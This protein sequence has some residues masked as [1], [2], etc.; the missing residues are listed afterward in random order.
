MKLA[1]LGRFRRRGVRARVTTASSFVLAVTLACGAVSLVALVDHSLQNNLDATALARADDVSATAVASAVS[2]VIPSGGDDGSIVQIIDSSGSVIASSESTAEGQPLLKTPPQRREGTIFTAAQFPAEGYSGQFRIVAEPLQLPSG[3]GW[4]YVATSLAQVRSAVNSLVLLLG[5][6]LP[7]L[8]VIVGATVWFAVGRALRPV[9]DIRKRAVQ[10]RADFTQRI[11]LPASDDEIGRLARTVNEM[12]DRL[13]AAAGLERRF[14]GDA[15]HELRS[16][17]AA[18]RSQVDVALEHPE[19]VEALTVLRTIQLQTEDMTQLL[20]DLL[21][22]ARV[23]E[24]SPGALLPLIDLDEIL[25]QEVR[26]LQRTTDL[27]ISV[28]HLDAVRMHGAS[29]D[30]ARMIANIGD[31]ASNYARRE[32]TL[33]LVS[34][35]TGVDIVVTDDGSGI[36]AADRIR[37]FDRFTRLDDS[38]SRSGIHTGTG[39]GLAIAQQIAEKHQGSISARSRDD[40]GEGTVIVISLPIAQL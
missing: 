20:E 5:I 6:G 17:L 37:I 31:N 18:I 9:E 11:P 13:S 14:V 15:S 25:V 29:R 3:P 21:F 19:S 10:I 7:I 24:N 8:L 12:L 30:L 2:P 23:S 22:L 40:E 33:G 16:P 36:A 1:I 32:I 38:R 27:T 4:V 35:E 34:R 39:L 28:A 26:R